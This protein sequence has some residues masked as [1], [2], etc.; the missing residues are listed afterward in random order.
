MPANA[1]HL[2]LI[3]VRPAADSA[4]LEQISGK[5]RLRGVSIRSV[6]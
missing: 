4:V 5:I 2:A 6:V 3:W 1:V